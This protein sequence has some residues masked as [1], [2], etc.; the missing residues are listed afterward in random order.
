MIISTI[1]WD[2][3]ENSQNL[4]ETVD[5][6][7]V[8]EW[9]TYLAKYRIGARSRRAELYN[10]RYAMD[11][12]IAN[13]RKYPSDLS[14]DEWELIASHVPAPGGR[15]VE[16]KEVVNAIFY[17]LKT[18]CQWRALPHD[19]PRWGTV[20]WYWKQWRQDCV[21]EKINHAL[22]IDLRAA[23]GRHDEPS[24]AVI[25]SQSFKAAEKGGLAVMT[26]GRR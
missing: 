19:F 17:L 15:D 2:E 5:Y 26:R 23:A 8:R 21:W 9:I 4:F 3:S 11:R 10:V 1:H 12:Q 6:R 14:D 20:Y 7:S 22:R 18:G 16:Y 25:D 13:R 24:A